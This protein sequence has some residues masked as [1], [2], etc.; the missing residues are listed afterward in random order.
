MP[1]PNKKREIQTPEPSATAANCLAP[2]AEAI[3]VSATLTAKLEILFNTKGNPIENSNVKSCRNLEKA[4]RIMFFLKVKILT[5][6]FQE[7]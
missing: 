5:H 7:E 3:K 2:I 6:W 4:N 1:S